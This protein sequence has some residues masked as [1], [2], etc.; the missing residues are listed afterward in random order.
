MRSTPCYLG[1]ISCGLTC[2]KDLPCGFHKCN[3]IC[4]DGPCISPEV[5]SKGKVT[6][7]LRCPQKCTKVRSCGHPCDNPCHKGKCPSNN[8]KKIVSVSCK[9][10]LRTSEMSCS[11]N[12]REYSAIATAKLATQMQHVGDTG[13]TIDIS[14]II[15]RDNTERFKRLD[16]NDACALKERN[17]RIA[18]AL[19]IENPESRSTL[20][21]SNSSYTDTMKDMA[22]KD[23]S[24]VTAVHDALNTLVMTA[25][26]SKQP[27]RSHWFAPMKRDKRQFIHEYSKFFGCTSQS[28][29]EEPKKNVVVVA[30]KAR[31]LLP[32][33]SIMD[34]ILRDS[35]QKKIPTPVWGKTAP[36][37]AQTSSSSNG[38]GWQKLEKKGSHERESSAE[39]STSSSDA[40]KPVIDYFNFEG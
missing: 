25:R 1:A 17:R 14:H 36:S 9:C 24:F 20:G 16:C 31:C 29:D 28:Y 33:Y 19:Q 3:K 35:G 15:N 2:D 6:N 5:S 32:V 7:V 26:G 22:K 37:A 13:G 38:S 40:S 34:T 8:C 23:L 27:S 4:H 30:H 11:Q 18:L 21:N 39:T 12:E 10:G